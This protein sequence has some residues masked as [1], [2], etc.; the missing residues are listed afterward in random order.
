[1]AA[2]PR[3]GSGDAVA[4]KSPLGTGA[5]ATDLLLYFRLAYLSG[6][7]GYGNHDEPPRSSCNAF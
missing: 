2:R 4:R 1:M 5:G 7:A 6:F 3:T